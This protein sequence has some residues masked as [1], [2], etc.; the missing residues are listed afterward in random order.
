MVCQI[1]LFA[2]LAALSKQ[3]LKVGE[4]PDSFDQLS[5]L[6]GHSNKDR[7]FLIEHAG[8]LSI[9]KGKWKYIE[10]SDGAAY[11]KFTA[12]ELGNDKQPQLYDLSVDKGEKNNLASQ[13]PEIVKDLAG[14]LQKT[15]DLK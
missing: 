2:S 13:H 4:A 9:T 3:K 15:R 11:N 5:V 7:D 6:L 10:P 14:L 1:D 12:T 8:T